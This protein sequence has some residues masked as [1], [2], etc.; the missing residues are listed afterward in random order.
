MTVTDG[1]TA[2]TQLTQFKGEVAALSAALIW[3]I[4]SY[5]YMRLGQ[6]LSPLILNSLKSSIAV[7]LIGLTLWLA[8]RPLPTVGSSSV[9]FLVMSGAIGIGLG[10]TAFFTS[11]NCIGARRALL[12]EALAPPLTA[13]LALLFLDEALSPLAWVGIGLTVA[14]VAWVVIERTSDQ[15]WGTVRPL[16]GIGFGLIAALGQAAGSVLSR[17]ALADTGLDPLWSTLIRLVAGVLVLILFL[18]RQPRLLREIKVVRSPRFL[19]VLV[20]TAFAGT[21]L[22]IWLQQ[23]ALKF[24]A[25]GIAQSLTSTSPLF[26]IPIAIATRETVSVRAIF[27]VLIA[28]SGIWLLFG[29]G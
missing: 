15:V 16:R 14:G 24:T 2:L 25:A 11:I 12:L 28:L 5:I 7:G 3:A 29:Q 27:G 26:V 22:A 23:T 6:R 17:A 19:A 18:A 21:Y 9:L 13:L 1:L 20:G 4:A 10:D 8:G